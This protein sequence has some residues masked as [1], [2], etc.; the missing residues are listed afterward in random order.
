[1]CCIGA[2]SRIGDLIYGLSFTVPVVRV[3]EA[4]LAPRF[5]P[6]LSDLL[7]RLDA[8]LTT[9]EWFE[10]GA[11]THPAALPKTPLN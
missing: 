9:A 2:A 6:V 7:S 4:G 11:L 3:H 8:A 1:V 5:R 10:P